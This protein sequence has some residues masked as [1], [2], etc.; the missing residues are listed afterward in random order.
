MLSSLI[1]FHSYLLVNGAIAATYIIIRPVFRLSFFNKKISRFQRLTF[2]RYLFFSVVAS[3]FLMPVIALLVPFT[4]NSSF[5]LEPIIKNVSED[6]LQNFTGI[7]TQQNRIVFTHLPLPIGNILIILLLIGFCFFLSRYIK[8]ILI[9]LEIKKSAF[10]HHKINNVNILFSQTTELPFCWSFIQN[11]YIAIPNIFLEKG[12]ELQLV[13]RHELQHI[14]QHDTYWVHFIMA[15]KLFCFWNPF[16][17]LWEIWLDE[18]QEFSCDESIILCKKTSPATYAECLINAASNSLSNRANPQGALGIHNLSK[19]ILYRRISM[20]FNYRRTKT[21]RISILLAYFISFF[22]IASSAFAV[23]GLS[24]LAPLSINQLET[25]IKQSHLDK[26][27]QISAT[28]EVLSE[29]NNIRSSDQARLYMRESLQRMKQYQPIIQSEL[30]K[31]AMPEELL[32]VPLVESGYQ[33]LD[34]AKNPFL[35]AGIWQFVP[36]TAERFNLVVN[37]QRDDRFDTTLSTKAALAYLLELHD[38][39]KDWKLAIIAYEYGEKL[40]DGF[41]STTNSDNAWVLARSPSI[42]KKMNLEKFV[43]MFDATVIIIKNPSLVL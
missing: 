1:S 25:I 41:I 31:H 26:G 43:S 16:I 12:S 42:S 2:I 23:N 7:V 33:Q 34:Q 24:S 37:S 10:C 30:K 6:L 11:H 40:T 9:L 35:A 13:I 39:Y 3:F 28:S 20:L 36:K 32:A 4:H 27:F 22:I 5:H 8:N 18:L 29:V 14:R 38:H 17:K 19:L 21:N 15:V